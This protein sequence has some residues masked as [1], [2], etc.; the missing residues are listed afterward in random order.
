MCDYWGDPDNRKEITAADMANHME[1]LKR[2]GTTWVLLSGGEA[3]MH[4][5][6][7]SL[8][9]LFNDLGA[10]ISLLTNGLLLKKNAQKIIEHCNDVIVSLDGG[11]AVHDRI[12]GVNGAFSRLE[13][14][15]AALK[16]IDRNYPVTGRSVVQKAN[17]KGL[18]EVIDAAHAMDLDSIS[19]LAVDA[20]TGAF[21][22]GATPQEGRKE[23]ILLSAEEAADFQERTE[24]LIA[25]YKTDFDRL[26]IVESP[27]KLRRLVHYFAAAS[28]T[29]RIAAPTCNAPWV[30]AVI[31][32][33]GAVRP[34]F[35]H[36]PYGNIHD[37]F[38]ERILNSKEA[39]SFRK[40]LKIH[41]DPTCHRCVCPLYLRS[42]SL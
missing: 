42:R 10:R 30:S 11:E 36:E 18:P 40:G 23:E 25:E 12:R 16:A 41:K 37:D 9:A 14:G 39:L 32:A 27:A 4:S 6:L 21:N 28:G 20:W 24:E 17:Y 35:F 3:L 33:D 5:D 38:L 1:D 13:A 22:R 7:W 29:A 15:V 8:C 31:E 26:Y 19:F 34:C 2:L